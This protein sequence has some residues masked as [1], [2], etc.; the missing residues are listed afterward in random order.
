M[1]DSPYCS[2]CGSHN[3]SLVSGTRIYPHR[4]D[5]ADRKFWECMCG[6]YVGCHKGTDK[7]F[8]KPAGKKLRELRM[9]VHEQFDR[10][11]KSGGMTRKAAYGDM[12]AFLQVSQN[13]CHIGSFCESDCIKVLEWLKGFGE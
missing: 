5:L 7:P 3:C 2:E 11:W 13:N 4:P 8:G 12:A 9:K 1:T 10:L 6:A